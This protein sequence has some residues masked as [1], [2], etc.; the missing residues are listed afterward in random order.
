MGVAFCEVEYELGGKR[1]HT[2]HGLWC[3]SNDLQ[4]TFSLEDYVNWGGNQLGTAESEARTDPLDATVEPINIIEAILYFHRSIQ[5]QSIV[6]RTLNLND[7]ATPGD[8]TGNFVSLNLDYQ[9]RGF[10]AINTGTLAPANIALL[11]TKS[12]FGF[13]KRKGRM[14]LRGCIRNDAVTV[15]DEDGATFVTGARSL[16]SL[17]LDEAI[18]GSGV[19]STTRLFS[20]LQPVTQTGADGEDVAYVIPNTKIVKGVDPDTGLEV[21]KRILF[22]KTFVGG[23]Q[24]TDAQSRNTRRRGHSKK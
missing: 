17:Q 11:I 9:C 14:F 3:A 20:Y 13:S 23:L 8:S 15:G 10:T 2:V 19:G 18:R 5:H 4:N 22:G 1:Y 7:G 6:L 12:P 21:E 24:V 16:Y